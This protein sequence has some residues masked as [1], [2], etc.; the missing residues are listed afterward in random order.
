MKGQWVISDDGAGAGAEQMARDTELW[1][2]AEE[3]PAGDGQL[4]WRF[5]SF[6]PAVVTVGSGERLVAT[7]GLTRVRRPTGGR[8]LYHAADFSFAVA[9]PLSHP[10]LRGAV[11]DSGRR[12]GLLWQRVLARWGVRAEL[13]AGRAYRRERF[14]AA[15]LAA[16]DIVVAGRKLVASAQRRGR[17]G[18]L[19]H[20]S[21][22]LRPGYAAA[23]AAL[24]CA[25]ALL[26][27]NIVTLAEA[28]GREVS[29]SEVAAA[30]RD[31]IEAE[32]KLW[33]A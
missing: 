5:Y 11:A 26:R 9:G 14:C 32:G 8:Q 10:L 18:V 16:G 2:A 25:E 6:V 12:L 19:V 30:W 23:A 4:R 21:L 15:T 13:A 20:G 28:A 22:A 33:H 3:G 31:I 27:E 17:R 7:D 29:Y 24:G 1:R